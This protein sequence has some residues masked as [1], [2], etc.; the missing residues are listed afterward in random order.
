MSVEAAAFVPG[1][2][3]AAAAPAAGAPPP[4]LLT[5]YINGLRWVLRY[6]YRGLASWAW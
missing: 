6:Y 4:L 5:E 2:P 1:S 3:P